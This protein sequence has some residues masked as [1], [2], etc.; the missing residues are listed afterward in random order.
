VQAGIFVSAVGEAEQTN[1][2]ITRLRF[3]ASMAVFT[4]L[5]VARGKDVKMVG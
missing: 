4:E 5:G 3:Y 2:I 1:D